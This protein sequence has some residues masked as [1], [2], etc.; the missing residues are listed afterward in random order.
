M[1]KDII[2][3]RKKSIDWRSSIIHLNKKLPINKMAEKFIAKETELKGVLLIDI[4]SFG[5]SRGYFLESYNEE[6]FKKIGI[7]EEFVQDNESKSSKGV[8]RGLHLQ[9]QPHAQGK[10]VRVIKGRIRDVVVDIRKNSS[11]YGKWQSF[12]LEDNK[13]MLWVPEGFAHGFLSLEND[14]IVHYKVTRP[15]VPEAE[16]GVLWN[17]PELKIDWGKEEFIVSEKDQKQKLFKEVKPYE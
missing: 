7:N 8:V 12:I 5:D 9:D 10:L 15:W 11:T 13:K 3:R 14:T 4:R 2:K 6:D 1:L 16:G 17:D